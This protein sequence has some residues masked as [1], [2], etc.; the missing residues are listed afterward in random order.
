[1]K[2]KTPWRPR[3]RAAI[4]SIADRAVARHREAD[5]DRRARWRQDIPAYAFECLGITLVP[6]VAEAARA[7]ADHGLVMVDSCN[8]YGKSVLAAVVALWA[9]DTADP[10][11]TIVTAP[12]RRQVED[13]IFRE[14]RRFDRGQREGFSPKAP[15]LED[16]SG[17]LLTGYTAVDENSF[18]GLRSSSTTIVIEEHNGIDRAILTAI[19]GMM[20]GGS[21][22][23][24][25][26]IGNPVDPAAPARA[27]ALAGG[28]KVFRWSAFEHPNIAAELAGDPPPVPDAVRLADLAG[29]GEQA[30][31][32]RK[33]GEYVPAGEVKPGDVDLEDPATYG[34]DFGSDDVQRREFLA[35]SFWLTLLDGVRRAFPGRFWRATT[36]EGE[37][38]ILARYPSQGVYSAYA[39]VAWTVAAKGPREYRPGLLIVLG[40]DVAREGDDATV[41]HGQ[42]GGVSVLHEVLRH[43]DTSVVAG[44]LRD[45]AKEWAA[46][47]GT[48]PERIPLV[49]D[50]TG[51]GGGVTDQLGGF[52]RH[53]VNFAQLARDEEHYPDAR[54][55]MHFDL[56]ERLLAGRASTARLPADVREELAR[57]SLAIKYETPKGRR[58][59][60]A[61]KVIKKELG[62]SPDDLTGMALAYYVASPSLA[63]S[64]PAEVPKPDVPMFI[65]HGAAAQAPPKPPPARLAALGVPEIGGRGSGSRGRFSG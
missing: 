64:A 28:W 37:A 43:R 26:A 6:R 39:E 60:I 24:C 15:R 41:I 52:N 53:P 40:C 48:Q 61:S 50:D 47:L 9:Y 49:V 16:H 5:E 2:A 27:E 25:L 10:S 13:I 65:Q 17:H 23:R 21:N 11:V 59:V 14:V 29:D 8:G 32:L 63:S 33:W 1:M 22:K 58:K 62:R 56:A 51:V 18:Q 35:S 57:Q 54:S 3:Q 4:R 45:L 20:M 7:L 19:R 46:L 31:N 34:Y 55:E 36:P 38:R 42:V 44:R 12:T 30:G